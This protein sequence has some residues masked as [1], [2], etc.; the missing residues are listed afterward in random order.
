[1]DWS[2]AELHL[3]VFGPAVLEWLTPK[4]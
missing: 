2:A 3:D 1:M 4:E